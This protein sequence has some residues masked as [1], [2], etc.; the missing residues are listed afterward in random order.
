MWN[1]TDGELWRDTKETQAYYKWQTKIRKT[2]ILCLKERLKIKEN[3]IQSKASIYLFKNFIVS[4][5]SQPNISIH[6]MINTS[7]EEYVQK[8][9]CIL[10]YTHILKFWLGVFY[11]PVDEVI[12]MWMGPTVHFAFILIFQDNCQRKENVYFYF[13]LLFCWRVDIFPRDFISSLIFL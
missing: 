7:P 11:T 2:M 13:L 9:I 12:S 4:F 10:L 8:Y 6:R 3:I 5:F 1:Y